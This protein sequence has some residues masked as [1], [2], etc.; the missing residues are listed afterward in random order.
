M[1]VRFFKI[2]LMVLFVAPGLML[3]GSSALAGAG[4]QAIIDS[5]LSTVGSELSLQEIFDSLGYGIDVVND[6]LGLTEFCAPSEGNVAVLMEEL[7][8]SFGSAYAGWYN[9]A[10]SNDKA[11]LFDPANSANDS[12]QFSIGG[13]SNVG[14]YFIPGISGGYT[15]YMNQAFNRDMY[16]HAK[17]FATNQ[18]PNEYLVCFEDLKNGG[19]MDFNDLIMKVRF[20]NQ[21]PTVVLP[22]DM[23][24]AE[25]TE[26]T[27]CFDITAQ[28]GNCSG[29]SVTLE[30]VLGYGDF[31][32]VSG[33]GTI[34]ATHCFYASNPIYT[35]VFVFKATD[36]S[37]LVGYDTLIIDNQTNSPPNIFVP[38]D[39]D[40][41]ICSNDEICFTVLASD[42]DDDII[43]FEMLEG[44]GSI[45]PLTGEVCFLPEL[46]DSAEYKFII[47]AIDECCLHREE[48]GADPAWPYSCPRDTVVITVVKKP[49][50]SIAVSDVDTSLCE[51]AT[52]C[53]PVSIENPGGGQV[54]IEVS[55]PASYNELSGEVCLYVDQSGVHEIIIT[56]SDDI[57]G[58]GD[59]DTATI[60]V[61]LNGLPVVTLPADTS[62]ILCEPEE[63][64]FTA[65]AFDPDGD[66][67][68]FGLESGPGQID[69][70]TGEV[71][72]TPPGAG[73]YQ[74]VVFVTDY[75]VVPDYD[76]ISIELVLNLPPTVEVP[77]TS[78]FLC[79]ELT[80]VCF[81]ATASDPDPGDVPVLSLVS[82]PGSLDAQTGEICFTPSTEGTY[83]FIVRA[84]DQCGKSDLDT[85]DVLIGLNRDPAI[86]MAPVDTIFWCELGDSVCFVID[87][88]DP[89][90]GQ[91]LTFEQIS[92]ADGNLDAEIGK[93]CFLPDAA[94]SYTFQFAVT[95]ECGAADTAGTEI[96]ISLN[97]VPVVTL[98]GNFSD[99]LC[100]PGEICFPVSISDDGDVTVDVSPIG[101][102]ADGEV[103]FVA[104]KDTTY[105]ITVRATD[106]CGIYDEDVICINVSVNQFPTLSL[107]P[108]QSAYLCSVPDSV[109]FGYSVSDPDGT[110]P[111]VS[112]VSGN[113]IVRDGEICFEADS[114]GRYYFIVR[115]TDECGEFDDD[116]IFITVDANNPPEL[117]A[118]GDSVYLLCAPEQICFENPYSDIDSLDNVTF[119]LVSGSGVVFQENGTVC[120]TP[121]AAGTYQFVIRVEDDCGTF[122]QDTVLITVDLDSPPAITGED[123]NIHV[124]Y[125]GPDDTP[126]ELCFIGIEVSDPDLSYVLTVSRTCGPGSFDPATL[127]TCFTPDLNDS[128][129]EFCYRVEDICGAYDDIHLFVNVTTENVCDTATCLTVSI[130]DMEQC[131]YNNSNITLNVYSD[132]A[133]GIGG[134]DVL[135]Q[136]DVTGFTFLSANP[137]PA[138]SNWEYF[139][140]RYLANGDCSGGPC[141]DGLIRIVAIA[142]INNGASHPPVSAFYPDG[143]IIQLGFH[144]TDD[145]NFG[146]LFFPVKFFWMD[147]GDNGFSSIGGDTLFV[148]RLILGQN[149]IVWDEFN[150]GLYPE[151][152]RIR[153]TGAPDSCL[154][155]DKEAPLRCV[156]FQNGGICIISPDSIDARGD[157]NLNE[158]ANEIADVVL[159]TNYFIWGAEV[160]TINPP[161]QIAASDVN[162]D[163]RT[164]TVGDL[165]YMVRIITGDAQPIP[166]LAPY[167]M[168][169]DVEVRASSHAT[170]IATVTSATL[171]AAHFV[172][173]FDPAEV[174]PGAPILSSE[175][176]D[177]DI[178]YSIVDGT[179]KVLIYSLSTKH[180]ESGENSLFTIPLQG[181]GTLELVHADL[182]DYDGNQLTVYLKTQ[183]SLP[184]KFTLSQ[185]F[186]NPFN[187]ET[188]FEMYLP[189]PSDWTVQIVNVQG[190][191]VRTIDGS[192]AAGIVSVRWDGTNDGGAKVASGIYFYRATAGEYSETK[193]MVL[194]K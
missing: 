4:D 150:E 181:D 31:A 148:D 23:V 10:D 168:G 83:Q 153:N 161:G 21:P 157:M 158:V 138:L 194:L 111:V 2:I 15:W 85:A 17:V 86:V 54:T 159:Y 47:R 58:V 172:F 29:D 34:T 89:D 183:T 144:V 136:Y 35:Y 156:T 184:S 62:Y 165:V 169:A 79:E 1:P 139:T 5:L 18:N 26:Q 176:S 105:C 171:G 57:C 65:T 64:C 46:G 135:M 180:I 75:C 51:P 45:D 55:P 142:D 104:T 19:D 39:F 140:Y 175:A 137:G 179:M 96:T 166:K 87:V 188:E 127:T 177:L 128:T 134:F 170:E 124:P 101:T 109:C 76:T 77:D 43:E 56:A 44:Y 102:Y 110:D 132:V 114:V 20:A 40:T 186:P 99:S 78:L 193:K 27:V 68:T 155:G 91:S 9:S 12:V 3:S 126:G 162:A 182:S 130:E 112:I 73:T 119:I 32:P 22:D 118:S 146:G 147:C 48:Q 28:A 145:V 151:S 143:S 154:D 94:G 8:T 53:L 133:T 74:W 129:Y 187:P 37:G 41:L 173:D 141:P 121:P 61:D 69:P 164:L 49:A 72:F 185:N 103:C 36:A 59:V 192:A 97:G 52:V 66:P 6:E 115:A 82:G 11:V 25:C 81:F 174:T 71:C 116:D 24:I 13:A 60:T 67:L 80:E 163:G 106:T 117:D 93:F 14:I 63:F 7:S 108:D 120:F 113:G 149:I 189:A 33:A 98:P 125:C 84:I 90:A 16:D 178:S 190:Q 88:D 160:F 92:G 95:D 30:M 167:G 50:P 107:G 152:N 38:D 191:I 131:A 123:L 42:V 70:V 100:A 122:D